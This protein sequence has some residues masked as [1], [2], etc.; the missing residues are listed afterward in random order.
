METGNVT[1]METGNVNGIL[2]WKRQ[3]YGNVNNCYG[4][5]NAMETAMETSM[6]NV[7]WE[8]PKE[9]VN[10]NDKGK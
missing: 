6:R 5:V 3:C 8:T 9:N 4:N 2:L 7:N 1:A 10:I